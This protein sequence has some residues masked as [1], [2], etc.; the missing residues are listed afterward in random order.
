MSKKLGYP[1]Q[2][3]FYTY[4]DCKERTKKKIKFPKDTTHLTDDEKLVRFMLEN[5]SII[6][7]DGERAF[8]NVSKSIHIICKQLCPG[9][10]CSRS[11]CEHY[12]SSS[13]YNCNKT[14]PAV[15]KVYKKYIEDKKARKEKQEIKDKID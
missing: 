13:A 1:Q 12:S 11:H 3:V 6:E 7:Q 2:L 15:C 9:T 10:W 14:R 5:S 8:Q 4:L